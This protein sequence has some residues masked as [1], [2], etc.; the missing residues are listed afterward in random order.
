VSP[1]NGAWNRY[2]QFVWAPGF[3]VVV[4]ECDSGNPIII[5]HSECVYLT[6]GIQRTTR[7]RHSHLWPV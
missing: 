3:V 2:L 4:S 6:L 5:T 7:M 1:D